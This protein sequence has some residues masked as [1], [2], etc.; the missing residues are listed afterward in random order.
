MSSPRT[1]LRIAA[2]IFAI[3]ALGH[4]VRL[5]T[6]AQVLVGT[7]VIPMAASVIALI[8]AVGL[9]AW[10]WRLSTLESAK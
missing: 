2:V 8:I 9:S 6:G 1:G 10:M 5:A 3:F 4:L 7:H